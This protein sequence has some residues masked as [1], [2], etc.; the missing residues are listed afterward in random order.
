[1]PV[2]DA[3]VVARRQGVEIRSTRTRPD[4]TFTLTP[5]EP[6]I[7]DLSVESAPVPIA[8]RPAVA[9]NTGDITTIALREP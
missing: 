1:M 2:R 7:Y 8:P 5:L 4:G 6:G 9:V 3:V